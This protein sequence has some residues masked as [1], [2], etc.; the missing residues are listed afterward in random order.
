MIS[1]SHFYRWILAAAC[2][3]ALFFS[4]RFA[5]AYGSYLLLSAR[6]EGVI[7]QWEV[8][9][10]GAGSA[11]RAH[12]QYQ[13]G[14]K[15]YTGGYT[16]SKNYWN[17]GVAVQALKEL[18]QTSKNVFYHPGAPERSALERDFP[19]G[20]LIKALVCWS[21]LL[22]FVLLSKKVNNIEPLL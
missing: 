7:Q 11:I 17:E 18:S 19:K 10:R 20:L 13:V 6:T 2:L 16:F 5:L 15:G 12:Y 1:F 3:I 8:L 4:C 22:Y 9:D 14:G 21:V